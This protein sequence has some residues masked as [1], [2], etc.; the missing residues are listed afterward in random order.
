M[1]KVCIDAGH[2]GSDCGAYNKGYKEKD[3][4]LNLALK[5]GAL[6]SDKVDVVYT[7]NT[8]TTISLSERCNISNKKDCDYFVSIHVNSATNKEATGIE[9]FKYINAGKKG[10]VLAS[11]IQ[12]NLIKTTG[13]KNRGVKKASYYVLKKT[14]APAVLVECGFISNNNEAELLFNED[15]QDKIARAIATGLENTF[16]SKDNLNG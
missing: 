11:S 1:L 3:I 12:D 9:T 8:D 5:V 7:R 13:A 6:I 10:D 4:T 14:I 2:G 16:T 15:Y